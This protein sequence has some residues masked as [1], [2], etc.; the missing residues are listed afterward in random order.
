MKKTSGFNIAL[1]TVVGIILGAK[2]SKYSHAKKSNK[3]TVLYK[4]WSYV[5]DFFI[6]IWNVT[7]AFQAERDLENFFDENITR[8]IKVLDLGCGTGVNI[9]R[10]NKYKVP[11]KEYVGVDM[12]QDMLR[13]ARKKANNSKYTFVNNDLTT[14]EPDSK[15]DLIISTWVLSHLDNP[16]EIVNKYR[17]Y[18]YKGGRLVLIFQSEIDKYPF[19]DKLKQFIEKLLAFKLLTNKEISKISKQPLFYKRYIFGYITLLILKR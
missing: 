4:W 5:Y 6:N 13:E 3:I 14:Y 9:F 10:F 11:L 16:S 19:L 15:F 7:L 2:L 12:S 8:P 1:F 18:L 17:K